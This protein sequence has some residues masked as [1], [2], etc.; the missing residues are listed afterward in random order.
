MLT[1]YDEEWVCQ[2]FREARYPKQQIKILAECC[3]TTKQEILSILHLHG[4]ALDIR[5]PSK[6]DQPESDRSPKGSTGRWTAVAQLVRKGLSTKEICMQT[7][8]SIGR[9]GNWRTICVSR[10]LMTEAEAEQLSRKRQLNSPVRRR[11]LLAQKDQNGQ[12]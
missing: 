6:P 5:M 8:L 4:L 7:G 1:G 3:C 11:M 12:V 2:R 10:G 9:V